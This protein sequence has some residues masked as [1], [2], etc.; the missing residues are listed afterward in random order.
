MRNAAIACLMTLLVLILWSV[1]AAADNDEAEYEEAFS[2]TEPLAATGR[3]DLN[4]ISGDVHIKTWNRNEVRIEAVKRS[5]AGTAEAARKNAARITIEVTRQSCC[6][7]IET[8]YPEGRIVLKKFN[9]S[10]DYTLTVPAGARVVAT[11]V[12][13]DVDACCL[14]GLAKLTSVSGDIEAKSIKNGGVFNTVSGSVHVEET[15]GDVEVST[16][17][18]EITLS[19]I[20][21]SVKA[22][23]VSGS[24]TAEH[25]SDAELVNVSTHSG[26][27]VYDGAVN[28]EGRYT[29]E[30]YSGPASVTLPADA[31]FDFSCETFSGGIESD[32]K[33]ASE[34]AGKSRHSTMTYRAARGTVNG[35]GADVTITTFSG[36][37][38]L[39]KGDQR[40]RES[41]GAGSRHFDRDED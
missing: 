1:P 16:V 21:G 35:G 15:A 7:K 9:V 2:R 26:E 38:E 8:K 34:T 19:G 13:G 24:V 28:S 23:S 18:G 5:V 4:N 20:S 41:S 36:P 11:T 39:R 25:L 30:T 27:I 33:T 31:A 37:I 10:V 12:S 29:F 22:E 6:L 17:S 3:V 32:F 14:A 40:E